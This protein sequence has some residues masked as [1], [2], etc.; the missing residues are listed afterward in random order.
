VIFLGLRRGLV[1]TVVALVRRFTRG[2]VARARPQS[3][4]TTDD[5]PG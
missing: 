2:D 1:P 4:Y 5:P 3:A